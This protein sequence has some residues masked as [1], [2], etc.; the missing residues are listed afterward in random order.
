[1]R[2]NVKTVFATVTEAAIVIAG[3]MVAG[4]HAQSNGVRVTGARS[5]A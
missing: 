4:P 5:G 1:M 2:T 3:R